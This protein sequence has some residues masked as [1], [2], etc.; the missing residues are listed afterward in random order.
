MTINLNKYLSDLNTD[1]REKKEFIEVVES[2][3]FEAWDGCPK[4]LY[5][6]GEW[7]YLEGPYREMSQAFLEESAE[8]GYPPAMYLHA[9]SLIADAEGHSELSAAIRLLKKAAKAGSGDAYLLLGD[10]FKSGDGVKI[11]AKKAKKYYALAAN[12]GLANNVAA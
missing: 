8:K 12:N 10:L 7:F 3:L 6:L 11:N 2:N 5:N 9:S 1:L 4:A